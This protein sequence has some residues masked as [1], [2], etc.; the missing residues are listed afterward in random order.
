MGRG[1]AAAAL[2]PG[3]AAIARPR[4]L[5]CRVGSHVA[6]DILTHRSDG[7]PIFWPLSDYRFP[8]PVSYWEP[9]YHGRAFSLVCDS[10]ILVL[11]IQLATLRVRRYRGARMSRAV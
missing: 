6:I 7:Y 10:A 1:D 5:R 9:A 2:D 11:L 8:T 4:C 3:L